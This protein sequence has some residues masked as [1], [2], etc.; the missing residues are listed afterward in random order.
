[1]CGDLVSSVAGLRVSP[2]TVIPKT[3]H[4]SATASNRQQTVEDAM[5]ISRIIPGV[6]SASVGILVVM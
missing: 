4:T 3:L 6:E 5:A 1:M 2:Q